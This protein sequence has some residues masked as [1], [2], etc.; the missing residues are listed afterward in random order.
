MTFSA[1]I[2]LLPVEL[3]IRVHRSFI[4]NKS[5]ISHIEGNWVFIR[6][7]EIPI[8]SNYRDNFLKI[9]GL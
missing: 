4:V 5:M 8:A 2:D 9:I 3:F 6:Q 1:L 7:N